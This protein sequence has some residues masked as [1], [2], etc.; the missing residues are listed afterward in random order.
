MHCEDVQWACPEIWP[1]MSGKLKSR[2]Q[3]DWHAD[4]GL[5]LDVERWARIKGSSPL[6]SP[7]A[8]KTITIQGTSFEALGWLPDLGSNQGPAD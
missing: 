2:N 6:C 7:R 4:H 3:A 5:F 1:A 8:S